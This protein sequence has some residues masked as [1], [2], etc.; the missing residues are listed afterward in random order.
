MFH[1][2]EQYEYSPHAAPA[3]M[4]HIFALRADIYSL[5]QWLRRNMS[6][7]QKVRHVLRFLR[8]H[9]LKEITEHSHE[10]LIEDFEEVSSTLEAYTHRLELSLSVATSLI[11]TIDSRRS[12]A[13][14]KNISRLSYLALSF[15]PLTFVSGLFSMNERIA[16]GGSHFWVYFAIVVPIYVAI[17][18]IIRFRAMAIRL[19]LVKDWRP[20]MN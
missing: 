9:T 1:N 19:L 7:S 2:F 12:L 13:E 15:I 4:D 18:L 11:Q 20:R 16:P 6:S 3:A 8:Y 14:T 17:S 5:Q 10:V